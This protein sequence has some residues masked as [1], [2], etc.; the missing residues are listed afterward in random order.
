MNKIKKYFGEILLVV[1]S[2]IS[3]FSFFEYSSLKEYQ[4]TLGYDDDLKIFISLGVMMIV[5]GILFMR[6]NKN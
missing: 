4:I 6:K 5:S 2:G 3:I 1:G